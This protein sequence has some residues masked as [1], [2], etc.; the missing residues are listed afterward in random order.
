MKESIINYFLQLQKYKVTFTPAIR[1]KPTLNSNITWI[2]NMYQV[3][4]SFMV[5]VS[6]RDDNHKKNL[7]NLSPEELQSLNTRL[8][9]MVQDQ[10]RQPV[11]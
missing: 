4:N 11:A 8:W 7:N 3:S 5:T 1:I 6:T 9:S 10:K 2:D